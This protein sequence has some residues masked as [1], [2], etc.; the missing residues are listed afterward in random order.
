MKKLLKVFLPALLILLML[1]SMTGCMKKKDEPRGTAK[2]SAAPSPSPEATSGA[3]ETP[4][5]SGG[6]SPEPSSEPSAEP[7]QGPS[8]SA[9]ALFPTDAIEGFMEGSVISPEDAPELA[10]FLG[11]RFPGMSIQSITYRL[12]EDRQAYYVVLQGEGEASHPVYVFADG[13]VREE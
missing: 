1:A 6:P 2:P 5:V 9:E 10:R 7:S 3:S 4:L 8:E 12:F 13:S 11:S